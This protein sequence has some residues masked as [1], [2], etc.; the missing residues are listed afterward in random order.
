MAMI[1]AH[2]VLFMILSLVDVEIHTIHAKVVQFHLVLHQ[3]I[4]VSIIFLLRVYVR[5]T[6]VHQPTWLF[7]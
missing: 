6:V 2:A 5:L 1:V 4:F 3:I 7:L